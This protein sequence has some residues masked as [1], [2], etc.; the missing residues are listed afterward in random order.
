MASSK[1]WQSK[2]IAVASLQLD[3]K[4]PRLGEHAV[5]ASP[6]DLIQML[7]EHDKVLEVAESIAKRGFFPNE[8]LLAIRDGNAFTVV[9]GNRRLA[10]L[11]ALRDPSLLSGTLGRRVERLAR[12]LQSPELFA[13]V[14]VIVAPDRRATDRQVAGKHVGTPVLPW[15]AEN[16]ASF[17]LEKL[18]E[19]YEPSELLEELGFSAADVQ[20]ARQTKAIADI[21]RSLDLSAELRAK[22]DNPRSKVF[23]T[24]GRLFES[25]VGRAYLMVEPD[26]EHGIRGTTSK[27]EF[28]KGFTRLVV[29][30][31]SGKQS[32]RTLNTNDDIKAYFDSWEPNALPR[33]RRGGGFVVAD[34][35]GS[36]Q[37]AVV[38]KKAP[39]R[40]DLKS[41]QAGIHPTIVPRSLKVAH[42]NERLV[43]IRRELVKLKRSD[44]PNAG[45]VLL[46][47]FF[48]LSAVQYLQRTG[49]LDRLTTELR[50]KGKL[51][52]DSPT[53]RQL[54][55][56]LV[57][58]AKEKLAKGEATKVEKALK[59]DSA[60]PFTVS[61]LHSFVHQ[62]A[63]LPGERDIL[64]FW[65]RTEPLFRLMLESDDSGT[66]KK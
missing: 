16:R 49:D 42:G 38:E 59:Y 47:V 17:I 51:Q 9:E 5:G 34:I 1:V 66:S 29:D 22:L 3:P 63:E 31:A 57:R 54:I 45:A 6:H 24:L 8:P 48:E 40:A 37:P 52:H 43:D 32:S 33:K 23:S 62:N 44:Y 21:A 56:E 65:L 19:G 50:Q 64:Q 13:K 12:S 27:E 15:Q 58:L 18:A 2:S 7:F 61:D 39:S 41:R 20:A 4:N 53:M 36:T 46:R 26:A 11:K 35:T 60:A 10:A 28:V 55:P 25:T 14:P 30:V